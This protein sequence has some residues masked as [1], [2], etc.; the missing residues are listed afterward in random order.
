MTGGQP[1][2][3]E[4]MDG[5]VTAPEVAR[6]LS[7]EGVKTIAIVSDDPDKYAPGAFPPGVEISH[8]DELDRVQKRLRAVEGVSALSDQ[9]L[10]SCTSCHKHYRP[11]YG[12]KP[13]G[14]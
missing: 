8:R 1:I 9:L 11:G 5:A 12:Q 2:E 13:Q 14:E 10:E 6:Q 7:A 3:G 4:P